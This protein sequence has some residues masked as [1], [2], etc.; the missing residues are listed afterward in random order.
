MR[1]GRRAG[2]AEAEAALDAAE[3][4]E[5]ETLAAVLAQMAE[6]L[7]SQLSY[8]QRLEARYAEILPKTRARMNSR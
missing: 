1:A 5:E 4:A 2:A 3:A 7:W 6:G 8:L